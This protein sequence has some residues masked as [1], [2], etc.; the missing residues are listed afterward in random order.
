MLTVSLKRL[1][2]RPGERVLDLGCGRG[3]HLHAVV[4][5]AEDITAIGV[6]LSLED[7]EATREGFV[8]LPD[9]T[10]WGVALGDALRLPFA[11]NTFDCVICSEVLEHI[12]DYEAAIAEIARVIK[13]GGRLAVSVPR[14]W[15]EAICWRLSHGYRTTPGGHVRI[16]K[17]SGLAAD[18]EAAGF[19]RTGKHYAHGLHSPYWWLKCALWERRDD[20][21]LVRVYQRFLEW[22]I[23]KAPRLTR[24]LGALADPVM[25]KSVALYFRKGTAV[26]AV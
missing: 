15:P 8:W 6:D 18:I 3:R 11:D 25:G 20:H 19:A 14:G 5:A 24:W 2:L 13:P 26:N 16:F 12:I 23:L 7:L 21:P 9:A 4:A 17:A 22:D 1:G 10:G